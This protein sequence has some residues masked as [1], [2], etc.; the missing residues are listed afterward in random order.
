MRSTQGL[1]IYYHGELINAMYSSTCGGRTEDFSNVFDGPPVPYLTSVSCTVES[2]AAAGTEVDLRGKNQL[3]DA[4]F[5]DDGSIA[6]RYLE[7][8]VVLEFVAGIRLSPGY[9][10]GQASEAEIK[11][12]VG[13][14]CELAGL[15]LNN[16]PASAKGGA[17]R[18]GFIRFASE[19]LFGP[20]EIEQRISSADSVYYLGNLRDGDLVP[21]DAAPALAY[22]MQKGLWRPYPDNSARPLDP[23]RRSD[24]LTLLIR[25]LESVKPD[26]LR[27]GSFHAAAP[28]TLEPGPASDR[29][30][31]KWGSRT[32]QYSLAD[33]VRLFRRGSGRSTAA[34]SIRLIGNEKVNYHVGRDGQID[35]LE[36]ELNPTGASSDRFS[37]QAIWE[38]TLARRLISEK[39]RPLAPNIG[40]IKNLAPERLG[41]SGRAVQIRVIGTRGSVVLNGNRVR[42][43]LGLKDT[44]FTI[45]RTKNPDGEIDS[46]TFNGRG[47]G[48]GVGLCQVG[49]FGMARGGRGFEDILKT[50]YRGVEIRK[51]Y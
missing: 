4:L 22:L 24:A 41:N 6:N 5:A 26:I 44:L 18:A 9:V 50:Y 27:S 25:C 39:L 15:P 28:A 45:S 37:P 11:Q 32:Q 51:A 43:A 49:A 23:I 29:I 42:S 35:F 36:V 13:R 7:L 2:G 34:E 38:T 3:E 31:L 17:S 30:T 19:S 14:A 12:W 47:W 10:G 20:Q 46:L 21:R 16:D 1:A 48:H 8:A 33:Q 40:E